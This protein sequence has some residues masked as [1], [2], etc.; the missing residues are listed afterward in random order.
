[1]G[2]ARDALTAAMAKDPKINLAAYLA[3]LDA[4][5]AELRPRIAGKI[6]PAEI[7]AHISAYVFKEQ[8]FAYDESIHFLHDVLD[9]K[10][11]SSIGLSVL[12][13]ALA[14][15][16]GVPAAP[17]RLPHH[18][19]VRIQ[20]GEA[21]VNVDMR[22][23]G[24]QV[25]DAALIKATGIPVVSLERGCYLTPLTDRRLMGVLFLAIG[26]IFQ[27]EGAIEEALLAYNRS[28]AL[29]EKN[30]EAYQTRARCSMSLARYG[31]VMRDCD[32]AFRLNPMYG[33]GPDTL[34]TFPWPGAD[35]DA[36]MS[37]LDKVVEDQPGDWG[38]HGLRGILYSW[39][40]FTALGMQSLNEALDMNP[41]STLCRVTRAQLRT[42][43]GAREGAL[44]DLR[45][46]LEMAPH[47]RAYVA[48]LG[49]FSVWHTDPDYLRLITSHP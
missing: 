33:T 49:G 42:D 18:M 24:A 39:R 17:I 31:D 30:V 46:A 19:L 7:A 34:R 2:L 37:R 23:K 21:V 4:M 11:G 9:M 35:W 38:A 26:E 27:K 10:R 29:D 13:V 43:I 48:G 22:D 25:S 8:K 1:M 15:A 5:A 36:L 16:V 40:G 41:Y 12:Y 44:E 20:A 45:Q 32:A 3:I 14:Q 47:L 6:E 28:I